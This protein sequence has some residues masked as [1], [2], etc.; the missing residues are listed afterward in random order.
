MVV[1]IKAFLDEVTEITFLS[2]TNK[3]IDLPRNVISGGVN[4]VSQL[5]TIKKFIELNKIN[6]TVS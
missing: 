2:F 5:N 6:K 1:F 4:A 3:T